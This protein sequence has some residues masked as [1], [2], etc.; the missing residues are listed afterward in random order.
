MSRLYCKFQNLFLPRLE[1][2]MDQAS[3]K[4]FSKYP[5]L[6]LQDALEPF[7]FTNVV[8]LVFQGLL[9]RT[10]EIINNKQQLN[11]GFNSLTLPNII[12]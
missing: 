4:I 1:L 7:L 5:L 3:V 9:L 10:Y 12:T 6:F 2:P 11:Y 8:E